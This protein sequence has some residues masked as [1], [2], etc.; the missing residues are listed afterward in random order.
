MAA[1]HT[2]SAFVVP[3]APVLPSAPDTRLRNPWR[4]I[5]QIACALVAALALGIFF[6]SLP[7]YMAFW[8]TVCLREPCINGQV[9]PVGEQALAGLG[10]SMTFYAAYL[11]ALSLLLV[12]VFSSC[13]LVIVVRKADDWLALFVALMLVTFGT[14]T[15][16]D[17]M[18]AFTATYP[19]WWFAASFVAWFGDMALMTFIFIFPTGQI[20]PRWTLAVLVVWAAMQGFRFFLPHS[21]LDLHSTAP[22]IYRIVFTLGIASGLFAQVYRYRRVSGPAQRQQTKWVVF[23]IVVALGGVVLSAV[24]F[25][26]LL[27]QEHIGFVLALSTI[28]V[29]LMLLIPISIVV[30]VVRYR[31]WEIDPIINRTLVYGI[32]TTCLIGLYILVVGALGAWFHGQVNLLLSIVATGIAA[33]LFEPM[34]Q[35]LQR[36]VNRLMYGDRDDPYTVLVRLG[37]RLRA[38]I[39]PDA[40]LPTLVDTVAQS[41]KLPYVALAIK[42]GDDFEVAASQGT[43]NPHV[44]YLPLVYQTETTGYLIV[45]HR[46]SGETFS[47]VETQL[48]EDIAH[49]AG[50]TIYAVRL[51]Q[52][53]Q[54]SRERLVAAREEER[55]RLRRDLHDGLGPA[56]ANLTMQIETAR[57]FLPGDPTR[58]DDLLADLTLKAQA[59]IADIR[60]LVYDLRP[61]ALDEFGLTFALREQAAQYEHTGLHT[62]VIAPEPLPVLPAAVEVAAYRIAQEAL[63]NV[64]RHA[65]AR[66]CT[67]RVQVDRTLDL[68]ITDDGC[69]I[70]ATRRIGV[71]L[72][73]MRERV[74]ELGGEFSIA[75]APGG[76]T[77]IIAHLPLLASGGE[78]VA[79]SAQA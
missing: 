23:S 30:A 25:Q 4:T 74:G 37:Q 29:L 78:D 15:F 51:T 63:T 53:L 21:P 50:V 22:A 61:P 8:Q 1:M 67:V 76:G 28:Q 16:T 20:I 48:L 49:Q 11:A 18:Q 55:R 44:L 24:L 36:M 68:E 10:L 41:L 73:S 31:L 27:R 43:P 54:R 33:L 57:E 60:R 7:A 17:S 14:V 45:G 77:T 40:V 59:A 62:V 2:Q 19:Q 34:R 65:Q 6:A 79:R 13:A 71:G 12:T 9:G 3:P 52:D 56:L 39:A 35:R 5:A 64:A 66:N 70:P 46:S 47:P 75:S 69:G 38:T 58:A 26:D 32:L 72:T 42:R